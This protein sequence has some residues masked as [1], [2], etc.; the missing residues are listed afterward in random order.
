M[1]VVYALVLWVL[2]ALLVWSLLYA[3]GEEEAKRS[4]EF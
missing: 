2:G 3:H 1:W 4:A